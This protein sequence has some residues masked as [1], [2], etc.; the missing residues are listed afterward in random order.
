MTSAIP[1]PHEQ[2]VRDALAGSDLDDDARKLQIL[3]IIGS[4]QR[5]L[6]PRCTG[7]LRE[8]PARSRITSDRCVRVCGECGSHEAA[9]QLAPRMPAESTADWPLDASEVRA[10]FQAVLRV[11]NDGGKDTTG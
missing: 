11:G 6:C 1:S 7:A 4:V 9:R 3:W 2:C 10:Q 8:F 5:G